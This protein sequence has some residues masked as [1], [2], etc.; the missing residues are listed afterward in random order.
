MS[1]KL[2]KFLARFGCGSRREIERMIQA[3]RI[4]INGKLS[5]L[6]ERVQWNPT[7]HIYIDDQL[8]VCTDV[9]CTKC[10]VIAYYKIEGELCSRHDLHRRATV[11]DHLPPLHTERWVSV[12]RLDINTGGLLL[13]TTDG[14]L[15]HRLMH[16]RY[17]VEREYAV[18]VFGFV[19]DKCINLL[20]NGVMLDDGLAYCTALKFAGGLGMNR[21]YHMTVLE[22]RNREVR[23]L[24]E[25][26]GVKVSRLIRIR[27]GDVV[28]PKNLVRGCWRELDLLSVNSLRHRV[29]L[30]LQTD[31]RKYKTCVKNTTL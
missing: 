13:F 23:R 26:I 27:Y 6:G 19:N 7:L 4:S 3:G 18:R 20:R 31:A 5:R 30:A 25:A 28:L 29:G 8:I 12:G 16:P 15:A 10:R 9:F 2:Q 22:G 14:Q 17:K 1:E 24:W 11:F 21:W